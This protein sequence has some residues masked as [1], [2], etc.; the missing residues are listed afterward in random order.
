MAVER[1][2]QGE[3]ENRLDPFQSFSQSERKRKY[4]QLSVAEKVRIKPLWKSLKFLEMKFYSLKSFVKV[5]LSL[6][7]FIA[8]NKT[9]RL[10]VTFYSILLHG[11]IFVVLY[12][13]AMT[14]S[15]KHDMAAKWHEKY[16]EHM[17]VRR[18]HIV[19]HRSRKML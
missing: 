18:K 19:K 13:M 2:Y 4:G 5:I 11:L 7:R 1:R 8:S 14:E 16:I 15:C 6:V 9:A 3:Y 10:M 17:Q 12:K